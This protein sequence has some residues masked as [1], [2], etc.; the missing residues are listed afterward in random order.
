M[1]DPEAEI[2]LKKYDLPGKIRE[3]ENIIER[4]VLLSSSNNLEIDL[5]L[6]AVSVRRLIA[7]HSGFLQTF[8][9]EN[10]LAFG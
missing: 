2:L 3:L 1:L 8:P 6:Y 5:A 7:L 10:A 4:S 9:H